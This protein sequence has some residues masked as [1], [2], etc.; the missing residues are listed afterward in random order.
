MMKGIV[1]RKFQEITLIK[2]QNEQWNSNYKYSRN[3]KKGTEIIYIYFKEKIMAKQKKR[4]HQHMNKKELLYLVNQVKK[5]EK[6]SD[7]APYS[8]MATIANH[9][10]WKEYGWVQEL[11]LSYNQNVAEYYEKYYAEEVT[12]DSLNERLMNFADFSV[13]Y[14][15]YTEDNIYVDEKHHKF[16]YDMTKRV[17]DADNDIFKMSALY[18]L[19]QFNVLIDMGYDKK[20]IAK[21]KDKINEKLE[22]LKVNR[23]KFSVKQYHRELIDEVG[24]EIEIPD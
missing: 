1:I 23:G 18:N 11:L 15:S 3:F 21:H 24:I 14:A 22:F 20:F 9:T 16:L 8:G 6:G 13:E 17:M 19:I 12:M 2:N 4:K 5:A 10:L 7:R